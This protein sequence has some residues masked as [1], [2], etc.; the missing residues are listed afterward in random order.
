MTKRTSQKN[1]TKV[2]P[3]TPVVLRYQKNSI[4]VLVIIVPLKNVAENTARTSTPKK[5]CIEM[6]FRKKVSESGAQNTFEKSRSKHDGIER[7]VNNKFD[8]GSQDT[9]KKP[10]SKQNSTLKLV[11]ECV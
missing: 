11:K 3:K 9:V 10:Y 5:D 1:W 7:L 4:D 6:L 8:N 2:L